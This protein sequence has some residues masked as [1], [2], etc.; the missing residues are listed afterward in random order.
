M[1]TF[2][3][4]QRVQNSVNTNRETAEKYNK[5]SAWKEHEVLVKNRQEA[6]IKGVHRGVS[7]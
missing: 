1:N 3:I 5:R 6:V 4:P 2:T 7:L